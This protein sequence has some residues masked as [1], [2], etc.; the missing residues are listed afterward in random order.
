ML[1][2][3]D[4]EN[5][6]WKIEQIPE[7]P[8]TSV[9]Y[10]NQYYMIAH[11][12]TASHLGYSL[13]L[14]GLAAKFA[15]A[16]YKRLTAQFGSECCEFANVHGTVDQDHYASGISELHKLTEEQAEAAYR[17][18]EQSCLMYK[19]MLDRIVATTAGKTNRVNSGS[20]HQAA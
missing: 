5:L 12:A 16:I 19:M 6:G 9:F 18:L 20:D 1:A 4:L 7:Y 3:T 14:E 17:N 15:P 13:V 8:E 2:L 10:Q 11:E